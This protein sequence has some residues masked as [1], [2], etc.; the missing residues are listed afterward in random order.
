MAYRIATDNVNVVNISKSSYIELINN[1]FNDYDDTSYISALSLANNYERTNGNFNYDFILN[2]NVSNINYILNHNIT[3]NDTIK[4]I[5]DKIVV[6]YRHITRIRVT[7]GTAVA[8]IVVVPVKSVVA[9]LG[10]A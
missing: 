8:G 1:I 7:P 4:S 9:A 3:D 5:Y 2:N 10:D 6:A